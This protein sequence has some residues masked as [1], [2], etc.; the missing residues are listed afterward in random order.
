[1]ATD[2][3]AA[4]YCHAYGEHVMSAQEVALY[5]TAFRKDGGFDGR[6]SVT[7]SAR[8]YFNAIEAAAKESHLNGN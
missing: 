6:K 7:R 8:T 3:S 5:A 4:V 1:M 2:V